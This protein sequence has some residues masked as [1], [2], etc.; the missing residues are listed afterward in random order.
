MLPLN[1]M[2][3]TRFIYRISFM[4][5]IARRTWCPFRQWKSKVVGRHS[6]MER[7]VFE[8][9]SFKDVFEFR[10]VSSC[11]KSIGDHVHWLSTEGLWV[12]WWLGC[13]NSKR[14]MKV[15]V[16]NVPKENMIRGPFPSCN[17]STGLE[18]PEEF[19]THDRE[20]H[21]YRWKKALYGL[22]QNTPGVVWEDW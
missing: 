3:V 2:R 18:Q 4:Y 13:L 8:N 19:K 5:L 6:S 9:R 1:W 16:W 17:K 14:S 20:S 15:H 12:R 22:K 10:V 11:R 21:V 7:Y